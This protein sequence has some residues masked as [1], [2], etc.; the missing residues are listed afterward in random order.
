MSEY[1][2]ASQKS[3][4]DFEKEIFATLTLMHNHLLG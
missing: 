2:I 1:G 4:L 3:Y